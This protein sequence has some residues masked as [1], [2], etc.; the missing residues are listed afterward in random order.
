MICLGKNSPNRFSG[1][2]LLQ[3]MILVQLPAKFAARATPPATPVNKS[4][5][6]RATLFKYTGRRGACAGECGADE[7]EC[8]ALG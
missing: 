4:L 7:E 5:K 1:K 6:S 8:N 2:P 3:R